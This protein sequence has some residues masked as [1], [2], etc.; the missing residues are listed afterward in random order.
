MG[1]QQAGVFVGRGRELARA[2]LFLDRVAAGVGG[3]MLCVGEPGAGKTAWGAQVCLRAAGRN[4]LVLPGRALAA[5]APVPYGAVASALAP[6]LRRQPAAELG[7]LVADLPSLGAVFEGIGLPVPPLDDAGLLRTRLAVATLTLLGRLAAQRP[8]LVW[9]DDVHWLDPASAA[10]MERL[11]AELA[12]LPVALL[13]TTRPDRGSLPRPA[14]VLARALPPG[15]QPDVVELGRL[16]ETEVRELA[17]LVLG[18]EPTRELVGLLWARS[19]GVALFARELLS[20]AMRRGIVTTQREGAGLDAA[21]AGGLPHSISD[22]LEERLDGL[23]A[24]AW[25]VAQLVAL[26]GGELDLGVLE[27]AVGDGPDALWQASGMLVTAGV[28]EESGE[29]GGAGASLSLAHPLIGEVITGR[30]APAARQRLLDRLGTALR[31]AGRPVSVLALH[32]ARA[33]SAHGG[34][35]VLEI[36]AAGSRELLARGAFVEAA[37]CLEAALNRLPADGSDRRRAEL[38]EDLGTAWF[39]L[40]EPAAAAAFWQ[41]AL[42]QVSEARSVVR[43]RMMVADAMFLDGRPAESVAHARLAVGAAGH[44][45]ALTTRARLGLLRSALRS[46]DIDAARA[47]AAPLIDLSGGDRF[48]VAVSDAARA[49]LAMADRRPLDAYRLSTGAITRL[50]GDRDDR[51]TARLARDL[52]DLALWAAMWLGDLPAIRR[53]AEVSLSLSAGPAHPGFRWRGLVGRFVATLLGGAWAEASDVL[54]ELDALTAEPVPGLMRFIPL[55]HASFDLPRGELAACRRLAGEL[56]SAMARAAEPDPEAAVSLGAVCALVHLHDGE[57]AAAW[58]RCAS[59]AGTRCSAGLPPW[60]DLAAAEAALAAGRHDEARRVAATL[61]SA[62][63][64]G[65][66]VA[67]MARSVRARA[68]PGR[69]DRIELFRAA[70]A[71]AA[72]AMPYE[73]A[74]CRYYSAEPDQVRAALGTFERVGASAD[75]KRART[76][77]S[78]RGPFEGVAAGGVTVH[79][80]GLAPLPLTPRETEVASLVAQG[81]TSAAIAEALFVSLRTVTSHLEHIYTKLG[82]GSRA[83][84]TRLVV[85]QRASRA[86]R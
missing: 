59:W 8:A 30:L 4:F 67:A 51:E 26:A 32:Y 22:L 19:R 78:P 52:E 72:L 64:E 76:S 2:D 61:D 69:P 29:P 73:A 33:D 47:V 13:A 60:A 46:A 37:G 9:V 1:S 24:E 11:V 35:D 40:A 48:E 7:R 58:A 31:Q 25:H 65:S 81:L 21:W 38:M 57:P 66:Y 28:A 42:G 50:G 56:E 71:L 54:V 43:L 80:E 20:D 34:E 63:P 79:R 83:A 12:D 6:H 10:L 74:R 77:I 62:A 53:H 27:A 17:A 41:K 44:D 14:R 75:A 55:C 68:R 16:T 18:A 15:H 49:S 86:D 84:L 70:E 85:E 39:G 82:V 45:S 36:L 3:L 23:A 5:E